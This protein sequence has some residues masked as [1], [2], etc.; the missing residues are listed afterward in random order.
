[1]TNPAVPGRAQSA[2]RDD[3]GG[4]EPHFLER[5]THAVEEV[6]ASVQDLRHAMLSIAG[7]VGATDRRLQRADLLTL[8]ATVLELLGRHEGF[9]AGAG[10]VLAPDVLA[11]APLWIDWWWPDRGSGPKQLEVDLDPDSAEFYDYTTTEWYREPRRTGEHSIS[12]PYVDYIC[13]H[14]YTFTLSSPLVHAGRFIGIAGADILAE[15]VERLVLPGLAQRGRVTVLASGSGRIIASNAAWLTPGGV[16]ARQ[17]PN[18]HLLRAADLSDTLRR[19]SLPWVL[20]EGEPLA[21]GIDSPAAAAGNSC[22][23]RRPDPGASSIPYARAGY[24]GGLEA[25]ERMD[26]R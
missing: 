19:S 17:L 5:L 6:L 15:Q 13:T 1:M 24:D 14:E 3:Q 18:S 23:A 8:R 16:L 7:E 12:G 26:A 25:P 9:A 20:L 22:S 4:G 11:D 2:G 10:V 21:S